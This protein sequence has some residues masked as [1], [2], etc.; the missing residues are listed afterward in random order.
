MKKYIG[1]KMIEAERAFR[2]GDRIYSNENDEINDVLLTEGQ[3]AVMGYKVRYADGYESF[4]PKDVFEKAYLPLEENKNLKTDA[5]SISAQMVE[6]FIDEVFVS[7]AGEKTT[8]VRAVLV[9][10][11]EIVESSGCV[12]K[13]NYDRNLGFK[14][15]MRQIRKRVWYLLGFLLQT[16]V[17]GVKHKSK[18]W[19][20][21]EEV[22]EKYEEK[23]RDLEQEYAEQVQQEQMQEYAEQVKLER[24][25]RVNLPT[26][27]DALER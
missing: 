18:K 3:I 22:L 25:K 4:S 1:T 2:I 21:A 17:N 5:P 15:C 14:I 20:A 27:E 16:A 8:V 13:E 7:T 23:A 11:F 12:S 9:N 6:D 26:I 24:L 19:T 10:G